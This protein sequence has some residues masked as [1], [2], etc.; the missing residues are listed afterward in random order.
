MG[1]PDRLSL[2]IGNANREPRVL[3]VGRSG[4]D[5]KARSLWDVTEA[6]RYLCAAAYLDGK[7]RESVISQLVEQKHNAIAVSYGIDPVALLKHCLAARR[8]D[9]IRTVLLT[10]CVL[11]TLIGFMAVT[12]PDDALVITSVTFL[13]SWVIIAWHRWRTEFHIVRTQLSKG[14]FDRNHVPSLLNAEAQDACREVETAQN[15]NVMIYSGFSPFVG[16]GVNIG[17]WS[18]AVDVTKGK[19]EIGGYLQP[20]SFHVKDLYHEIGQTLRALNLPNCT[21]EDK[22][23]ISGLDIRDDEQFLPEV[24]DR[25]HTKIDS[26]AMAGYVA[27]PSTTARH[28]Q[29]FRLVDWSGEL[30]LNAFLR[31]S[32]AAH[33]LFVEVTYCLLV[34][35]D[36]QYRRV[37]SM[38]PAPT[39]RDWLRLLVVSGLKAIFIWPV[40]LHYFIQLVNRP[41]AKWFH[42]R[43]MRKM[44][45]ENPAYD[46]GAVSSL[47]EQASSSGLYRHYFQKLDKEMYMKI[48]EGQILDTIIRFLADRNIDTSDLKETQTR[49]IN[50]GII[51]SGGGSVEANTLAVGRGSTAVTQDSAAKSGIK[52]IRNLAG[53]GARAGH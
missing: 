13:A 34:P 4:S 28:Y 18:F 40:W 48:L 53:R 6:T 12:A 3:R 26:T 14:H 45:L 46:H 39:W 30:I 36:E 37:D 50:S 24:L 32:Q 25:P 19:E 29:N 42:H 5:A 20:K 51:V 41:I 33:S 49:I 27:N 11:L 52:F 15:G 31:A 17:G 10:L 7:F 47:R 9:T 8:L 1:N 16:C 21:L 22:V 38:N 35:V 2:K 23:C 44:V 43:E